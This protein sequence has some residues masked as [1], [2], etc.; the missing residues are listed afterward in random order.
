MTLKDFAD[1]ITQYSGA[2]ILIAGVLGVGIEITPIIKINPYSLLFGWIGKQVNKDIKKDIQTMQKKVDS[3]R[4]E[5]DTHIRESDRKEFKSIRN[6]ILL[7]ANSLRK[8]EL[9]TLKEY[10]DIMDLYADYVAY[11]EKYQF[12]N[13]YLD[14]EYDYIIRHFRKCQNTNSFLK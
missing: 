14:E 7:F 1:F 10:E 12:D 11:E 9:H 13:G 6:T 5:L 3:I 2:I 4:G 8:G